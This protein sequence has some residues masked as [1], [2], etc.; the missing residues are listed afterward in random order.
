MGPSKVTAAAQR[1][2]THLLTAQ[3][4]IPVL[5]TLNYKL[6]AWTV[7]TTLPFTAIIHSFISSKL[8]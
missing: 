1:L 6:H 7:V 5:I 3:Y 8:K 4:G 2:F